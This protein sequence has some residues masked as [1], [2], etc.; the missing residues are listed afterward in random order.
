M[1]VLGYPVRQGFVRDARA[2]EAESNHRHGNLQ[3]DQT[4]AKEKTDNSRPDPVQS[5]F[6]SL[7]FFLPFRFDPK[8][9]KM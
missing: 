7:R 6:N 2:W 8:P 5:V 9:P 1:G 4:R 3:F